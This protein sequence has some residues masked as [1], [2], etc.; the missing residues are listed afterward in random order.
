M[1]KVCINGCI[2]KET[3]LKELENNNALCTFFIANDVHYGSSKKTG[4]YKVTAWG[5]QAK[6]IAAHGKVGSELFITG[7][8]DQYTYE[9]DQGKTVY[10]TSIV[11][12]QFDFGHKVTAPAPP[13]ANASDTSCVTFASTSS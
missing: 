6:L 7:R 5:N 11:L 2:I 8:L 13:E 4:F 1:N 9:D 3:S 12:E 10:D